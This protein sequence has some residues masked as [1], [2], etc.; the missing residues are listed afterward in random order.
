METND[1]QSSF[2]LIE[3]Y[4]DG[5]LSENERMLFE[6]KIQKDDLLAKEVQNLRSTRSVIRSYGYRQDLKAIHA[7]A[8][9][10]RQ[11][12][13]SVFALWG[14]PMRIAASILLLVVCGLSINLATVSSGSLIDKRYESYEIETNRGG[15]EAGH[16]LSREI[17]QE[18]VNKNYSKVAALYETHQVNTLRETFVV[19]NAYMAL[20]RPAK[21]IPAFK[22]VLALGEK[23]RSF[24]FFHDAEYYLAWAYLKNHQVAEADRIFTKI[25][26]SD[27]HPYHD[28]INWWFYWQMKLIHLK[29]R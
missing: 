2:E 21:A 15:F 22:K 13:K 7:K 9:A 8:M 1:E 29:N 28:K 27:Y 17:Q 14:T 25:Y 19:A 6:Q 20:S 18:Y 26:Q 12:Q 16:S 11:S 10:E 5:S 24:E 4:L 23:D 3:Q